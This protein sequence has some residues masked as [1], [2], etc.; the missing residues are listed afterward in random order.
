[1]LTRVGKR[2]EAQPDVKV[3][4]TGGP[5]GTSTQDRLVRQRIFIARFWD[6]C[7]MECC[8]INWES[9]VAHPAIHTR[10][11]YKVAPPESLPPPQQ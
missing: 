2:L 10:C 11:G 5:R 8:K 7:L 6:R 1:M 4:H 9:K 3:K